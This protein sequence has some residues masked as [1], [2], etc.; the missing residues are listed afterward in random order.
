MNWIQYFNLQL[1]E[2][3]EQLNLFG[4]VLIIWLIVVCIYNVVWP[5][6]KHI[7]LAFSRRKKQNEILSFCNKNLKP[8]CLFLD[9]AAGA[10][11]LSESSI[12]EDTDKQFDLSKHVLPKIP[13]SGINN[14]F[15]FDN[16]LSS[17]YGVCFFT[18]NRLQAIEADEAHWF[19]LK[20]Y[21]TDYITRSILRERIQQSKVNKSKLKQTVDLNSIYPFVT[22]VH[23]AINLYYQHLGEYHLLLSESNRFY[24]DLEITPDVFNCTNNCLSKVIAYFEGIIE[25]KG[26]N[27]L[28]NIHLTDI[29]FDSNNMQLIIIGHA[30]VEYTKSFKVQNHIKIDNITKNITIDNNEDDYKSLFVYSCVNLRT[31]IKT[32]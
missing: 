4:E 30:C 2:F 18:H 3:W 21:R 20:L 24:F 14:Y 29:G 7:Y 32:S 19:R 13:T 11:V 25:N 16:N 22:S 9:H 8:C 28:S 12:S 17:C 6:I 15:I 27:R 31:F 10:Y 23:F 26:M 5:I 1:V